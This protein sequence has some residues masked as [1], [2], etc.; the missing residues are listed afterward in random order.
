MERLLTENLYRHMGE[1]VKIQGW[2]H[3]IR[4]MGKI[5]F[6]II[7]DRSGVVQCVL[8]KKTIDIKGLKLES[9]VEVIGTVTER[10]AETKESELLVETLNIISPVTED[11]PVEINKEDLAINIDTLLNN[12]VLTLR[13]L[14]TNAIFKIQ[15]ALAQGFAEFL[16]SEDFTQV[17][18]P[19]IVAE[20]TE[21]GTG[22]FELKYFEKKAYLAQS[23]QFYKQM[24]VGA[25]YERVFEIGHVYRAEEHN[26]IRHLNEY[27][28][29]D[30][31]MG[32][33]EDEKE[34]MQLETRLLKYIFQYVTNSCT[35]ELTLLLVEFPEIGEQIP[36]MK[37]SEAIEILKN[38]YG[39]TDLTNDLD[40]EGEKFICEYVKEK[41]NSDFIFLTHYPRSKRPM[42]TMPEGTESTHSFDL[43]FRGIEI[44]TGGQRIHSYEQLKDNISSK[45][46]DLESFSGYLQVFKYGM[47]PHGGLAIGLERLTA[48]L[49]GL[50]NVREVT[51][52][53]RDRDRIAP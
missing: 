7:R 44:T 22:L 12:R 26:T 46:L 23:P 1:K 18:S 35:K 40:P 33:I 8:D 45:G 49:L 5:A 10:N 2:I 28:S 42:Y 31:E 43:L 17:Y 48:Q 50:R 9:V 47:P 6:L 19:K 29:M 15:A 24:L 25:G 53:P 37:L 52:F 41:Y 38:K 39:K 27:V 21:G 34:I 32:F 13:H 36:S 51:L 4:K 11:L 30:L 20:G 16:K 14:K 3:K